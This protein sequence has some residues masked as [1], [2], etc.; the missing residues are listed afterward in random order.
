MHPTTQY[1]HDVV[2]GD[3]GKRYCGEL[4]KLACARHLRDLERQGTEDFPYV[5]DETRA[6]RIIQWYEVYCRHV[7]GAFTGQPIKLDPWQKFDKGCLFGWV[8]MDTGARRFNI[9]FD[10]RARGNVKSTESSANCAYFMCADAIYPP[11]HPELAQYEMLPEVHCAAVDK[12]QAKRVWGDARQMMLASPEIRKRLIIK[13]NSV[14]NKARGGEM[15]P[16]SKDTNNK[17]SGAQ[18]YVSIDEYHKWP[19]SEI[20][21]TLFSGFGKRWQS[22]MNIIST[23]GLNAENNPCRKEQEICEKILRGEIVQENYYVMIRTLDA[24]DDPHDFKN[25]VKANPILRTRNAYSQTLLEQIVN[26]HE[27]AFGSNDHAKQREWLTKRC[28]LWQD[29]SE[30]KYFSEC[31]DAFKACAVGRDEFARLIAGR[32]AYYGLDLSK[33]IDLTGDAFAVLLADGRIAV[34]MHGYIPRDS[35][36]RHERSDR[37]P[38]IGWAKDGWCTLTQG[39]VVDYREI[40]ARMERIVKENALLLQEICYDPFNAT[41]Y[42]T[43]LES[44]GYTCVEVPQRMGALSE[45]TKMFRELVMQGKIVHDGSPMAYWCLSNAYEEIDSNGNTKLSKRNK[46]DTQ[47]IDPLAALINALSRALR[48]DAGIDANEVIG[49]DDWGL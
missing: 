37:V 48:P 36:E 21:D 30:M 29:A 14:S 4:E 39:Q 22:L 10:L 19:T 9:A 46:D 15:V 7:R 34:S 17:D 41:H 33:R 44:D 3:Y 45:P 24:G 12:D 42:C 32:P 1:A 38:Y 23:A 28:N 26:E 8:R 47:R 20:K 5:F 27:L 49:S 16:L 25:L 43:E 2:Y 11:G 18:T 35:A 31:M 6:D 13:A 40:R